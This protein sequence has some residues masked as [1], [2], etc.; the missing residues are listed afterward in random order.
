MIAVAD[1]ELVASVV[2]AVSDDRAAPTIEGDVAAGV[3][4]VVEHVGVRHQRHAV[5]RRWGRWRAGLDVV[6]S[7]RVDYA[8]GVAEVRLGDDVREGSL[9]RCPVRGVLLA[10]MV[11]QCLRAGAQRVDWYEAGEGH[12]CGEVFRGGQDGA[13]G[14]ACRVVESLEAQLGGQ[15]AMYG[16]LAQG[17]RDGF[18]HCVG[19]SQIRGRDVQDGGAGLVIVVSS[20]LEYLP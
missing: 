13:P 19:G 6:E 15:H 5:V 4:R 8:P 10:L 3:A 17:L 20:L 7:A 16:Y 12:G 18:G 2:R 9:R 14:R 11:E 1:Q